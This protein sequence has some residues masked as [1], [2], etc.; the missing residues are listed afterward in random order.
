MVRLKSLESWSSIGVRNLH[1]SD[2]FETYQEFRSVLQTGNDLRY[3]KFG[4]VMNFKFTTFIDMYQRYP[5]DFIIW[6]S[7]FGGILAL[8]KFS[9]LI[10][11]FHRRRH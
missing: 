10:L 5:D 7:R 8:L 9:S 1:Q 2:S 4:A 3:K 11:W 6:L